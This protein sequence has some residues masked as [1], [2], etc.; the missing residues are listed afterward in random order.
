M[1]KRREQRGERFC[2]RLRRIANVYIILH[3][4]QRR[5]VFSIGKG[6]FHTILKPQVRTWF[7]VVEMKELRL[8]FCLRVPAV[9]LDFISQENKDFDCVYLHQKEKKQQFKTILI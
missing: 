8:Y 1:L 4:K 2:K 9:S 7:K 6:P 3:Q 5:R